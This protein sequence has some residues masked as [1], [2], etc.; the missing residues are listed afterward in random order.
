MNE[1]IFRKSKREE[2]RRNL[3]YPLALLGA[4]PRARSTLSQRTWSERLNFPVALAKLG[5]RCDDHSLGDEKTCK[6]RITVGFFGVHHDF[7]QS[8]AEEIGLRQGVWQGV[9]D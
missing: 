6:T 3:Q 4:Y 2:D 5:I 7:V 8:N 1:T 9:D